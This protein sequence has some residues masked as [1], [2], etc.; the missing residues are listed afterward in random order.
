M[1]FKGCKLS[2]LFILLLSGITARSQ[3]EGF[4]I[5]FASDKIETDGSDLIEARVKI[6]NVSSNVL[7]GQFEVHS[8]HEDIYMSQRKPRQITLKANDSIFVSVK[9][10]VSSSAKAGN[11]SDIEAVFTLKSGQSK[12]IAIPVIIH[13]RKLVKVMFPELNVIYENAGDSLSVPVHIFN[14]GNTTQKIAILARYPNFIA[15]NTLENRTIDVRAFTDTIVYLKK[16]INKNILK[17]EDFDISITTLYHNGNIINSGTVKASSIKSNRRYTIPYND[18]YN[19]TFRQENQLTASTQFNNDKSKAYFLYANVQA[20]VKDAVIQANIDLNYWENSEQVFLRNTW[21]AYKGEKY[22]ATI[23]SISRFSDF[24]LMGRG[25]EVYYKPDDKNLIEAGAV[26]K[27]YNLIDDSGLSFGKSAW[28]SFTHNGGWMQKKGYEAMAIYDNDSYYGV[29]NYLASA[30]FGVLSSDHFNLRAGGAVSNVT[31]S[32]GLD[33]QAGGSGEVQLNGKTE[34]IYYSSSN[35]VSSAYFSGMRRGVVNLNERINIPFGK[36]NLWTAFNYLSVE[37]KI[38]ANQYGVSNFSSTRYD[39][40]MSTRFGS[41]MITLAPYLYKEQRKEQLFSVGLAK[42]YEMNAARLNL[43]MSYYNMPTKQN[44]TVSLEGGQFTTNT[45]S[46]GQYHFKA[47]AIYNWKML[48]LFTFYQYNNFYLGE[49]IANVQSGKTGKYTNLTISPTLQQKFFNNKLSVTAGTTYSDNSLVAESLQ[50]NGRVEY[51]ITT[52][53]TLFFY[54]YYSDFSTSPKP[55]NTYQVGLT[56]RF[57]PIKADRSKSDLEIYVYYE[58]GGKSSVEDSKPAV[59]Q[60]VIINGTAFRTNSKG[61]LIYKSLPAGSYAVKTLNTNE[62]Y[63]AERNVEINLDTK[64][65]IG[66]TRT[67]TIKGALSYIA[68]EKSFDITR[69]KN[70]LS[71]I[72]IDGNGK[73]FTTKTDDNGSFTL[74]VPKGTY[75]VTLEKSGISEYVEI[76]N[77]NTQINAEPNDIKEVKFDLTIKEKRVETKKF[78]SRGFPAPA[79]ADDKKK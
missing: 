24:N 49:I 5:S 13:E 44:V 39:I 18:D 2:L 73:V 60:L 4:T 53:F 15:R 74:Y 34:G 79:K 6:V 67:A 61:I 11:Q 26:D 56:K 69:R 40:G 38:Y 9:A 64:I 19:L 71:V 62:W 28:T 51:D 23:G 55:I 12:S 58:Q 42:Q 70:G 3:S 41:L 25:A 17:Q 76:E 48:S 63:A 54:N 20:E 8:S 43:G 21:L 31:S 57:N 75:T 46:G 37:P 72:A 27:A 78:S 66:L 29:N 35:Y 32:L 36:F 22:G 7:E 33:S 45:F 52:D 77:N 1:L 50:F 47:N 16:E 10:I 68:T 59:G 65:S 30:R 14:D